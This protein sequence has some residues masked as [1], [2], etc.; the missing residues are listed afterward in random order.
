MRLSGGKNNSLFFLKTKQAKQAAV[1]RNTPYFQ[2]N[3]EINGM[4]LTPLTGSYSVRYCVIQ[5]A[6]AFGK[7]KSRTSGIQSFTYLTEK[8]IQ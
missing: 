3:P 1:L 5:T 8:Q 7:T 2:E 4:A 6:K